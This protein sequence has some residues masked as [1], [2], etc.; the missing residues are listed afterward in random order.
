MRK[1]LSI[2]HTKYH[3]SVYGVHN[4]YINCSPTM[5]FIL[6]YIIY[7]YIYIFIY[8]F[9]YIYYIYIYT[10]VAAETAMV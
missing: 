9:I 2:F 3:H 1:I 10:M 6:C 7:V 4:C 5:N 8:I